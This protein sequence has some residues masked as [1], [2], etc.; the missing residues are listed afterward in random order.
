MSSNLINIK[1]CITVN[2]IPS[3]N[4]S[5]FLTNIQNCVVNNI[6]VV[7]CVVNCKSIISK[8][9]FPAIQLNYNEA[10]YN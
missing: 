7:V 4:I 1:S 3:R 6:W 9:Q 8:Y 10:L 2:P 5:D